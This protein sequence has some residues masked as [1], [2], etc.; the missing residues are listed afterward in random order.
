VMV[1]DDDVVHQSE[2]KDADGKRTAAARSRAWSPN[3]KVVSF[4]ACKRSELQET[5][6]S[7]GSPTKNCRAVWR[8]FCEKKERRGCG[9]GG[10]YIAR[11]GLIGKLGFARG[12]SDRTEGMHAMLGAVTV[13]GRK[14]LMGG[15]HPSVGEEAERD[16]LLGR[17]RWA[18]GHF[19]ARAGFG[20]V[21]FLPFFLFFCFSF[22]DFLFLL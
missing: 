5:V 21:A 2:R 14:K 9:G 11:L 19:L 10:L 12:G 15:S 3:P 1:I 18:V 4:D 22:S 7:G 13:Q 16:T 17:P 6:A 8:C 20:P